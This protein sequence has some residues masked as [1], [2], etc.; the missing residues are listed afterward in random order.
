MKFSH[1]KN[2]YTKKKHTSVSIQTDQ[3]VWEQIYPIALAQWLPFFPVLPCKP[4]R[5]CGIFFPL[6]PHLIPSEISPRLNMTQDLQVPYTFPEWQLVPGSIW[7]GVR[8]LRLGSPG[9]G[10]PLCLTEKEQFPSHHPE[11]DA[12]S[13]RPRQPCCPPIP[14]CYTPLGKY[15]LLQDF[16][17][18]KEHQNRTIILLP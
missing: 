18:F 9:A 12:G 5:P 2:K 3:K 4:S 13:P 6:I 7:N 11:S 1:L 15:T 16:F 10:C 8:Y 14:S 17:F